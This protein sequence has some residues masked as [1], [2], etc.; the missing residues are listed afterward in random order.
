[1][2]ILDAHLLGGRIADLL[3]R[4]RVFMTGTLLFGLSS[5]LCGLAGTAVVLIAARAVQGVSAAVMAPTALS[6]LLNTVEEGPER[7]KA[8]AVWSG[9]GGFGAVFFL[10]AMHSVNSGGTGQE[11]PSGTAMSW[12]CTM[13]SNSE[14]RVSR[15]RAV[16]CRSAWRLRCSRI[17]AVGREP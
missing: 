14:F 11:R 2:V 5:L 17:S 4:R 13:T 6:I 3:G 1:M 8:L 12:L 16:R 10:S 7:N 9:S 15:T